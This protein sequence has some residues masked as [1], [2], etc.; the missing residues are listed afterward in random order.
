M[1]SAASAGTAS[2]VDARAR[3]RSDR[4]G[5]AQPLLTVASE[6]G[7]GFKLLLPVR[8][9][10]V[11]LADGDRRPGYDLDA[12]AGVLQAR[13][14]PGYSGTAKLMQGGTLWGY[15][16]LRRYGG[17]GE[18][19]R[20]RPV[21]GHSLQVRGRTV[22]VRKAAQPRAGAAGPGGVSHQQAGLESL[23]ALTLQTLAVCFAERCDKEGWNAGQRY[24]GAK[25]DMAVEA[26]GRF[27]ANVRAV[28]SSRS[29]AELGAFRSGLIAQTELDRRTRNAR[30]RFG[31]E[32]RQWALRRGDIDGDGERA[33]ASDMRILRNRLFDLREKDIANRAQVVGVISRIR[34][35]LNDVHSAVAWFNEQAAMGKA[36]TA[37]D[38]AKDKLRD[39][40][41]RFLNVYQH[42]DELNKLLSGN[43][44]RL[45][46]ATVVEVGRMLR[47]LNLE[48][49]IPSLLRAVCDKLVALIANSGARQLKERNEKAYQRLRLVMGIV[50]AALS[51]VA[52][53]S[54]VGAWAVAVG[55]ASAAGAAGAAGGAAM[56]ALER[57]SAALASLSLV[58]LAAVDVGNIA[59]VTQRLVELSKG[60]GEP[61]TELGELGRNL[62]STAGALKQK[63]GPIGE[64]L[65]ILDEFQFNTW[66][67]TPILLDNRNFALRG[68]LVHVSSYTGRYVS[69]EEIPFEV[70]SAYRA[71][72]EQLAPLIKYAEQLRV[73]GKLREG[74]FYRMPGHPD[75]VGFTYGKLSGNVVGTYGINL[76]RRWLQ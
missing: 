64:I 76:V 29:L 71:Q 67:K 61:D 16:I 34:G 75:F 73:A 62:L 41:A 39:T 15:L 49:S 1:K 46:A 74:A 6:V 26:Y 22:T 13:I 14:T 31:D 20:V 4:A 12:R 45:P 30:G 56:T 63:G 72:R 5:T 11:A 52:C 35:E 28:R 42:L 48:K 65:K 53:F 19:I 50:G 68:V 23:R 66:V 59:V 7:S 37:M 57:S 40:M 70:G 43:R 25:Q 21:G 10:N 24:R 9:G 51:V 18:Q 69:A 58:P 38:S 47:E 60:E 32:F 27:L 8:G 55:V 17:P 33:T 44:L 54:G 36:S 3:Q 2:P